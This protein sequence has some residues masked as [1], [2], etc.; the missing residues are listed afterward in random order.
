MKIEE[1]KNSK[2]GELVEM[3]NQTTFTK[4]EGLKKYSYFTD[5]HYVCVRERR[6]NLSGILVKMLGRCA[7]VDMKMVNGEPF[8]KDDKEEG[9]YDDHYF[10][11]RFPSESELREVLAIIRDDDEL[12]QQLKE[13][14]MSINPDD[15]F[16]TRETKRSMLGTRKPCLFDSSADKLSTPENN[17]KYYTRLTIAYF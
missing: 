11:Y 6:V 3:T 7:A 14:K 5:S 16:W 12:R 8:C 15:V 17:F 4:K 9:F 2:K 1:I 13:A 10:S